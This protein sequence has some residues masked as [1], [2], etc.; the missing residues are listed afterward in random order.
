MVLLKLLGILVAIIVALRFKIS[1]GITLFGAG[2]LTALFYT[3]SIP[4][5]LEGYWSLIK[6]DNF[7]SLTGA[8]ILITSLGTLLSDLGFLER[9]SSGCQNL[10][11]GNRTATVTLPLLVGLMP[12][13]GGALL[14]APLIKNVLSNPKY[15]PEFKTT[16]NYWFRHLIEFFWPIYPGVI[17]IAG[18]TGMS[19]MKVGALQFPLS[20]FMAI[21]GYFFFARKIDILQEASTNTI[22]GIGKVILALW[23]ILGALALYAICKIHLVLSLV[24][25]LVILIAIRRPNTS[26]LI[27]AAK[28]GFSY[29]LIF[30]V[31]GTLSFQTI[32]ELSGSINSLPAFAESYHLPPA[33]LIIIVCFLL[34]FLTGMTTAYIGMGFTLLSGFLYKP[35]IVPSNILLAFLAGFSGM[36]MSP[37]HLC[38]VLSNSYFGSEIGKVYRLLVIPILILGIVGYLL[39]LTPWPKLFLP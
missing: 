32:L 13:P 18:L 16:V 17:L 28:H 38:L 23:P 39:T 6:S 19:I 37:T 33:V 31:F 8:V 2:L 10:Y 35:V 11:G 22:K 26:M 15:S 34:G 30:L 3:I 4:N 14:S 27:K 21:I 9:L 25:I 7:L 1:V 5:L 36:I 29:N 12:M 24:I 20:L